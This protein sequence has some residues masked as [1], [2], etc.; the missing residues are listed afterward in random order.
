[1]IRK[2]PP[3]SSNIH[4]R[5]TGECSPQI[6]R[7][8]TYLSN[9]E[10]SSHPQSGHLP[11]WTSSLAVKGRNAQ[12]CG[13]G[14]PACGAEF[15]GGNDRIGLGGMTHS[16]LIPHSPRLMA[17]QLSHQSPVPGT[18]TAQ[19]TQVQEF[20]PALAGSSMSRGAPTGD[21]AREPPSDDWKRTWLGGINQRRR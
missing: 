12:C 2:L 11:S 4:L 17:R 14:W 3:Y 15:R 18:L 7:V 10:A 1:M 19:R 5:V 6:H 16:W 21:N 9:G 20:H 8:A 13:R